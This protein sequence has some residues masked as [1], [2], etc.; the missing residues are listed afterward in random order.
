MDLFT[1]LREHRLR[2]GAGLHFRYSSDEH[3]RRSS[4]ELAGLVVSDILQD[5]ISIEARTSHSQIVRI[6]DPAILSPSRC[7]CGFSTEEF[8]LL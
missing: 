8:Q 1:A 6:Y 3:F 5:G 4:D 7:G 2:I